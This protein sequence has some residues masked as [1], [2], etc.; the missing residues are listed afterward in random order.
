MHPTYLALP[1]PS[2]DLRVA[3]PIH[4]MAPCI[5][6]PQFSMRLS[7]LMSSFPVLNPPLPPIE[8]CLGKVSKYLGRY[9]YIGQYM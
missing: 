9:R 8:Y 6:Y 5:F 7:I 2:P 3:I 1:C 4:V